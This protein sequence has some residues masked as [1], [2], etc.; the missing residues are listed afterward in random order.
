[1]VA[2]G[3]NAKPCD[4]V[5]TDDLGN[6]TTSES[7]GLTIGDHALHVCGA[8][9]T[10][11]FDG[12]LGELDA[13]S[14]RLTIATTGPVL[15]QIVGEDGVELFADMTV[16]FFDTA[17]NPRLLAEGLY[18]PTL[19]D[20]GAF[21]ADLAPGDYDVIVSA[22]ASGEVST[23]VP[24][25]LRLSPMPA[26][27][28]LTVPDYTEAHDGDAN[29]GNDM[30]DVDFTQDPSFTPT[31]STSDAPEPTGLELAAGQQYLITGA[32]TNAT[33]TDQYLDRDTFDL[34][35]DD[36]ANELAIRLDWDSTTSDLDYLVFEAGTMTPVATSNV[37][38]T[39][40]HELAQ[41]AVR[42]STHHWLWIGGSGGGTPDAVSRDDLQASLSI[43]SRRPRTGGRR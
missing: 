27:D 29:T 19:A 43:D 3:D 36:T 10:G 33:H 7:T 38:S 24:Y 39:T 30:I 26:C 31:P 37:T 1:M 22:H 35:T 25:R 41:F 32:S 23:A 21:L 13:D 5:E 28:P 11:H 12:L 34:A 40:V 16:R 42:P 2:C 17:V 15:A 18:D 20:H 6:G 14:Y 8:I 4:Y 9:D